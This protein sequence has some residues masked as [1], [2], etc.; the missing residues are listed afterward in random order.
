MEINL[1]LYGALTE[2][3]TLAKENNISFYA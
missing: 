3:F 1:M 2:K